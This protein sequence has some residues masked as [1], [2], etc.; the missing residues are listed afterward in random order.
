LLAIGLALPIALW[1]YYAELERGRQA[2]QTRLG[3]RRA[4]VENLLVELRTRGQTAYQEDSK[5]RLDKAM[6]KVQAD[7][8]LEDL[9]AEIKALA[10]EVEGRLTADSTFKRFLRNR[11]N[12]LFY[13]FQASGGDFETNRKSARDSAIAALNGV[14]FPIDGHGELSVA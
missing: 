10:A 1:Q 12:A 4:D 14:R 9:R 2:K 8:D 13:A 7:P 6:E 5:Q 11:E 3:E